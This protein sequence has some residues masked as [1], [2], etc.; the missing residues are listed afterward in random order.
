MP[1]NKEEDFGNKIKD[2]HKDMR[3]HDVTMAVGAAWKENMTM[4][5]DSI[6]S[7][8]EKLMYQ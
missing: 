6:L 2:L 7:E 3:E 8:A 5:F 1:G 4:G